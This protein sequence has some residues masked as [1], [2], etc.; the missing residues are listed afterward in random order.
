MAVKTY[1]MVVQGFYPNVDT[2]LNVFWYAG[3]GD[4]IAAADL[5]SFF[6]ADVVPSWLACVNENYALQHIEAYALEDSADFANYSSST[7]AGGRTGEA[8]PGF[9]GWAFRLNRAVRTV[10]NGR[11]TFTGVSEGDLQGVG[12]PTSAQAT[13]LATLGTKL[14]ANIPITPGPDVYSPGVLHKVINGVPQTPP[15]TILGISGAD[16]IRVSSQNTRKK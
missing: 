14:A 10:R 5:I 8:S 11:K 6:L 16:F 3:D 15:G 7:L 12:T 13:R 4:T 1:K 2:I 9:V